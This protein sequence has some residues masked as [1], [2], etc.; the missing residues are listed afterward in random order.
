MSK[1]LITLLLL[2]GASLQT[3]LPAVWGANEWPILLV[4]IL[5]IALKTDPSR[6]LY[7][8][9]LAGLLHDA[10]S[11]APLGVSLPFFLLIAWGAYAIREEV[12]GDQVIT[13]CVL[14]F[15]GGLLKTFYFTVVFAA[16]GLRPVGAGSLAVRL[17]GSLLL[18]AVLAPIVFLMLSGLSSRRPRQ[19][20]WIT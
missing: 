15:L 14:G 16:A 6:V 11:P 12:F 8:G 4:L 9:L 20:R 1:R 19:P 18:G 7:A 10:F 2:A 3:L 13:Y 17:G 5:C